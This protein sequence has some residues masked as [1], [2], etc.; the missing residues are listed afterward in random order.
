M[1]IFSICAAS[2][3]FGLLADLAAVEPL[4]PVVPDPFRIDSM[5]SMCRIASALW[6]WCAS[7]FAAG[8]WLDG[9]SAVAAGLLDAGV[10]AVVPLVPAVAVGAEVLPDVPVGVGS[11]VA[12]GVGSAVGVA[13]GCAAAAAVAAGS[14][15]DEVEAEAA[16]ADGLVEPLAAGEAD[17]VVGVPPAAFSNSVRCARNSTSLARIAGSSALVPEVPTAPGVAAGGAVAAGS[18]G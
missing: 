11:A 8:D 13:V 6:P 15:G 12:L 16:G 5:A 10:G 7:A 18:A 3:E 1:R 4:V 2:S 9:R 14:L 17:A